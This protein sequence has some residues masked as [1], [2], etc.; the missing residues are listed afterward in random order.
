MRPPYITRQNEMIDAICRREYGGESGYVEKVLDANPGLSLLPAPLPM[1]TAIV[2]PDLV[3]ET[4]TVKL[5]TLW[6]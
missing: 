2:L 1:G 6:D 5:V 3:R 4:Q